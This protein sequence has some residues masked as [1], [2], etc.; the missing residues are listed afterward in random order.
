MCSTTNGKVRKQKWNSHLFWISND[1][2]IEIIWIITGW[3][4]TVVTHRRRRGYRCA[5]IGYRAGAEDPPWKNKNKT[6]QNKKVGLGTKYREVSSI[7]EGSSISGITVVATAME[8]FAFPLSRS[9]CTSKCGKQM[10]YPPLKKKCSVRHKIEISVHN[11]EMN[12]DFWM[13]IFIL[14]DSLQLCD[15]PYV[16]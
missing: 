7:L 15:T 14:F 10:M 2:S 3:R 11:T 9:K 13:T 12:V 1:C 5:G 16:L 8:F 4:A 6:V